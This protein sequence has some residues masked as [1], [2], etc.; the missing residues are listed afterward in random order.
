MKC[1]SLAVQASLLQKVRGYGGEVYYG[2]NTNKGL[3]RSRFSRCKHRAFEMY[4]S[5]DCGSTGWLRAPAVGASSEKL[6]EMFVQVT[7]AEL[8]TRTQCSTKWLNTP[9]A[10]HNRFIFLPLQERSGLPAAETGHFPHAVKKHMKGLKPW[11]GLPARPPGP[12][13]RGSCQTSRTREKAMPP[14]VPPPGP[15]PLPA[16]AFCWGLAEATQINTHSKAYIKRAKKKH[17]V[18]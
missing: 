6:D 13:S 12:L 11:G 15:H 18:Q 5:E 16:A 4:L 17:R 3:P 9:G 1:Q 14:P 7:M 10:Q 8:H 2:N